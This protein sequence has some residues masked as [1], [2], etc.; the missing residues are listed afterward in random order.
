MHVFS[1]VVAFDARVRVPF[2]P[3]CQ[4]K[5]KQG[6]ARPTKHKVRPGRLERLTR[7]MVLCCLSATESC[8][9]RNQAKKLQDFSIHDAEGISLTIVV[10]GQQDLRNQTANVHREEPQSLPKATY[11]HARD[12]G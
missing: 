2:G 12:E 4:K 7:T 10:A 9:T 3:R 5:T 11:R 6:H 8:C 1:G